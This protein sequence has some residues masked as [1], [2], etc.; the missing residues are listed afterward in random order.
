[1]RRLGIIANDPID[2]YLSSGYGANWL[3]DY[4]NPAGFFDEVYSLAPYECGD[5]TAVGVIAV[6]TPVEDL[7]RRLRGLQIDVVRAYGGGHPSA[8]ACGGKVKDIP[9]IVSV[10]DALPSVLDRSIEDA[11]IVWCVSETV[12]RLVA[13]SFKR[14]DR[15]W[16]LPNR[17]DFNEMRPYGSEEVADLTRRYPFKYKI[18]QVGRKVWEKNI[19]NLIRSLRL[20]GSEYCLLAVGK[21]ST[22]QYAKVAAEEGVSERCFFIDAIPNDQLARYYSWAD[23]SCTPSRTEAFASVLIEALASGAMVVGSDIPSIR[24]VIVHGQNGLLIADYENPAAIAEVVKTACTDPGVRAVATANARP[25]VEP[26]ERSRVDALEAGYYQKV[27]ELQAAGEF[28]VPLRNRIHRAIGRR[29][30]RLTGRGH[31]PATPTW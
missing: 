26:F 29:A 3:K 2:L 22:D 28:E 27:I 16:L 9:V 15:V 14:Q 7:A 13:K 23:C 4:F 12:K 10:H 5:A 11:D 6:P 18:V 8:I 21:G 17:V 20:L 19:D 1:M 25:S 30:R 24:E 31:R